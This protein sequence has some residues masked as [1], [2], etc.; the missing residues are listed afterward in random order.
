MPGQ[1]AV[2]D[3]PRQGRTMRRPQHSF[4]VKHRPWVI[5]PIMIAPVLPGETMRQL[6]F[7]SRAVSDPVLSPLVG[8]WLEYYFFYVKHRDL[9]DASTWEDMVLNAEFDPTTVD[10]TT[11]DTWYYHAGGVGAINWTSKC[12]KRCV[13]EYFRDEGDAWNTQTS[14]GLPLAFFMAQSWM[15]S[16]IATSTVDAE[17]VSISTAGDN[18]FTVGELDRA[19]RTY[20]LLRMGELTNMSYEEWLATYGVRSERV[21]QNRPELLRYVR[22]WQYP[23]NT[24]NPDDGAPSSALSWAISE[25][26]DKDRFFPEPGFILGLTIA[27]PKVY[28]QYAKGSAAHHLNDAFAWLPAVLRDDPATS[29]R[30]QDAGTGPVVNSSNP[31]T[32][33]ARDLFLYGDQYVNDFVPIVPRPNTASF[34]WR[35]PQ[36]NDAT[37][38]DPLFVDQTAYVSA[39]DVLQYVRQDGICTLH[40][41]GTQ[42]DQTPGTA[43]FGV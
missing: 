24:I 11:A 4:R 2:V 38:V 29:L 6:L 33:D 14:E 34:A 17:D 1:V 30:R 20:Q 16:L 42:R 41:A 5:Q 43:I 36:A 22:Q 27:R 18:A 3:Q 7:Q 31:Y 40:V 32:W 21:I 37:L 8:W 25:R 39:A 13:E 26:A 12:L 10:E 35:T 9:D 23:S 19:Q 28:F 15:D